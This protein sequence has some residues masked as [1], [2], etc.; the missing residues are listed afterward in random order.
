M[1]DVGDGADGLTHGL[2]R[3]LHP[4]G[5]APPAPAT[6]AAGLGPGVLGRPHAQRVAYLQ[7]IG[8]DKYDAEMLRE[9]RGKRL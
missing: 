2:E 5:H 6:S 3:A 9:L 1:L 8:A 4:T 7:E